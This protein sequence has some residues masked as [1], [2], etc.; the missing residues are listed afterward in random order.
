MNY[1]SPLTTQ[2]YKAD[3]QHRATAELFAV[4]GADHFGPVSLRDENRSRSTKERELAR[5]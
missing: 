4:V 5:S 3:A 1:R 2:R